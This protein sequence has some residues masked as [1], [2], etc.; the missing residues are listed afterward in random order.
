MEPCA[1]WEGATLLD[2]FLQ[3]AISD[4]KPRA[5]TGT[6]ECK[7]EGTVMTVQ[8]TEYLDSIF[9]KLSVEGF[10][11][12]PVCQGSELVGSIS[13]LDLV[14][15]VNG[16]FFGC[17]QDD[18]I[19]W[20]EKQ[21]SFQLTPAS[22]IIRDRDEY[23]RN[24][25]PAVKESF[26]SFFA[27]EMMAR[28]KNHSVLSTNEQGQLTGILTQSMLISFLRQNKTKWGDGLTNLRV[29]DF[30]GIKSKYK[31]QSV[32]EDDIAINAFLTMG[33]E[34]VQGLP[35]LDSSG[36][37]VD[38]ISA[39]DLRCVGT[40]GRNF[41]RLYTTVKAFKDLIRAEHK[42]LA[43]TTHYSR[44]D[45]PG[46][47]VYVTPDDTMEAVI[48]RMDDGNLHRIF[49][50]S[51]ES[52]KK[53]QPIPIGVISQCDV[54]HQALV[55]MMS[56]AQKQTTTESSPGPR[57]G[58]ARQAQRKVAKKPSP[59]TRSQEQKLSPAKRSIPISFD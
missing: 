42:G 20:W 18:W 17:S 32:Q 24:P 22:Q 35:V 4:H 39:R 31:L 27:L 10:L 7:T 58:A 33:R 14:K 28:N 47:A 13:M 6:V 1:D 26:T 12:A 34:D 29:A 37:L 50:C 55:V 11:S 36:V 43:P 9:K 2:V 21:L 56:Q 8:S 25:F 45:I 49:I 15:H 16:L 57:V 54:L 5:L 30:Q 40:S 3:N 51:A 48:D 38:C 59:R 53:G 23:V 19:D 52:V 44:R 46:S 41:A